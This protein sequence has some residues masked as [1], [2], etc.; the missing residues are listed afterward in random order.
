M[1]LYLGSLRA[2]RYESSSANPILMKRCSDHPVFV[3]AGSAICGAPPA[4]R[5]LEMTLL[6]WTLP[7]SLTFSVIRSVVAMRSGA[8]RMVFSISSAPADGSCISFVIK[9]LGDFTKKIG[10]IRHAAR[11]YL[12]GPHGHLSIEGRA[13]AGVVLLAGGHRAPSGHSP[14]DG[15]RE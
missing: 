4:R 3:P 11:A 12:D 9:E 14:P 15:E 10:E 8:G 5:R 7:S 13:S 1:S 6:W 2:L